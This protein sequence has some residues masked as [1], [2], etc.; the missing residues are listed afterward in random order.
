MDRHQILNL[1]MQVQ[2]LTML[3]I[4]IDY[5]IQFDKPFSLLLME[6]VALFPDIDSDG[7][8]TIFETTQRCGD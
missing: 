6:E 5:F 8:C 2:L 1:G 3:M 7:H 4:I